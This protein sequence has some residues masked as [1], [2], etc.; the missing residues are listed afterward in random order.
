MHARRLLLMVIFALSGCAHHEGLLDGAVKQQ[1]NWRQLVTDDDRLRLR[2]WRSSFITALAA[3]RRAGNGLAIDRQGEMLEPDAA[4]EGDHLVVGSYHCRVLKLGG[5]SSVYPSYAALPPVPCAATVEGA[6]L[7]FSVLKGAQRPTGIIYPDS[8]EHDVFL[9]VMVLRD[10]PLPLNYG[11]DRTRNMA[12]RLER[13]GSKTWRLVLP[14]PHFESLL[15][16]IEIT[17]DL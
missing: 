16:V 2:D 17:Q 5:Q 15:D 4:I 8:R 9:G 1:V 6:L 7:R 14:S 3:A 10:E 12:G 11:R 13:V